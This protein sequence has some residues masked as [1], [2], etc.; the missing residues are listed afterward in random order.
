RNINTSAEYEISV[1]PLDSQLKLPECTEPLEAFTT[2]DSIKAGRTSI[3]IRC[4]AEKKWSI[5]TSAVI[6]VYE[7]VIVLSRSVQRGEIITRQH[8][9]TEKRD[10]SKFR[11]DF[12]TQVEQVENKQAARY[13]QAG[14]I[15]GLRSFIEPRLIKRGDKIIISAIQPAFAIRMNGVAMMDGTKSQLIRIKNENSGRI[16]NA[17]VIEPGL[18]SV[19]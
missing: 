3:G 12:I 16:I 11:G 1:L 2:T 9:A 19:K 17:T 13:T 10:V 6:K 5:F 18:V 8:L 15:L 4:N 14:T 7:T